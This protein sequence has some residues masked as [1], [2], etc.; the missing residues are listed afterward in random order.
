MILRVSEASFQK[1]KSPEWADVLVLLLVDDQGHVLT[2][3]LQRSTDIDDYDEELG[4]G[5]TCLS[6]DGG[7]TA[8][9]AVQ[10]WRRSGPGFQLALSRH[11]ASALGLPEV[12]EIVAPEFSDVI[13]EAL[14][15]L[16]R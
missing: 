1:L 3:E 8:Y 11:A 7:P 6:V 5:D 12:L 10:E 4:L 9:R 16:L 13:A 15:H 2:L 14:T